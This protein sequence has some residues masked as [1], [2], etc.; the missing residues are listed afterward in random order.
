VSVGLDYY[1]V[2]GQ[3]WEHDWRDRIGVLYLGRRIA[4][5]R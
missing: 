4:R 3:T 5:D 2:E 1:W